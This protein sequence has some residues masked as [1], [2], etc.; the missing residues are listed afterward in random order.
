M[1]TSVTVR[2]SAI[3]D[4]LAEAHTEFKLIQENR[5]RTTQQKAQTKR[6]CRRDVAGHTAAPHGTPAAVCSRRSLDR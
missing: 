1:Q 5:D 4:G 3:P 6:C 2:G